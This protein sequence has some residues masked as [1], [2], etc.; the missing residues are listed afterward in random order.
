MEGRVDCDKQDGNDLE[1]K[2]LAQHI[3]DALRDAWHVYQQTG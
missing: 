1:A 2:V 3:F